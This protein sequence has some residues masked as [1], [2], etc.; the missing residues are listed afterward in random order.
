MSKTER[1]SPDNLRQTVRA[2]LALFV[3]LVAAGALVWSARVTPWSRV[4]GPVAVVVVCLATAVLV[5]TGLIIFLR[6]VHPLGPVCLLLNIAGLADASFLP[7]AIVGSRSGWEVALVATVLLGG[8][9]IHIFLL[10]PRHAS[11][12]PWTMWWVYLPVPLAFYGLH[13]LPRNALSLAAT[14][15]FLLAVTLGTAVLWRHARRNGSAR[16]G[17][18]VRLLLFG[19]L[20]GLF[21]SVAVVVLAGAGLV[22]PWLTS[23]STV[24]LPLFVLTAIVRGEFM[25]TTLVESRRLVHASIGVAWLLL[26]VAA[27]A[28]LLAVPGGRITGAPA[29]AFAIGLAASFVP[30]FGPVLRAVDKAVYRDTYDYADL[31]RDLAATVASFEGETEIARRVTDDLQNSLNL[32]GAALVRRG[33]SGKERV[34]AIAGHVPEPSAGAAGTS[35]KEHWTKVP[36]RARGEEIGYML[37]AEKRMRTRLRASDKELVQTLAHHVG[38]ALYNIDL[39]ED[40]RRQLAISVAEREQRRLL[41]ARLVE[42]QEQERRRVARDLHDGPLQTVLTVARALDPSAQT[43]TD[44]C[45]LRDAVLDAADEVRN[46]CADLRP[47]ALD[48]LGLGHA[49]IGLVASLERRSRTLGGPSWQ[50]DVSQ[51]FPRLDPAHEELLFRLIQE[52]A[53]NAM[54]HASATRAAVRLE[55]TADGAVQLEV[56]DD[57]VG[58]DVPSNWAPLL[59]SGHLGIAGMAER[60]AL[61]GGK[62][63]ILS[64]RGMGTRVRVRLAPSSGRRSGGDARRAFL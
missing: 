13:A 6:T 44:R 52:A 14:G 17:E 5:T 8:L 55:H 26:Y 9:I 50:V 37:L 59:A 35:A 23:A 51:D 38:I 45:A 18:N 16:L 56:D 15:W 7:G 24:V 2:A 28:V 36:L 22:P 25:N 20:F 49:V 27:T 4:G 60:A 48:H 11:R 61:A 39:R 62:L 43:Q 19:T 34:L 31:L 12:L 64:S 42:A 46:I 33:L 63:E 57:G 54:R 29:Y 47:P 10:W 3:V 30:L 32:R 21:P 40:L 41:A 58:F 53:A 1:G